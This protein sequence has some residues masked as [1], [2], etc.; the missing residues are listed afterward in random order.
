VTPTTPLGDQYIGH[1][2]AFIML[3]VIVTLLF[4]SSVFA[5]SRNNNKGARHNA[6]HHGLPLNYFEFGFEG[7]T[8]HN[9]TQL[10]RSFELLRSDQF[11][12][13]DRASSFDEGGMKRQ[14]SSVIV[15][16]STAFDLQEALDSYPSSSLMVELTNDIHVNIPLN[17]SR[18]SQLI[19]IN[20][21]GYSLDGGGFAKIFNVLYCSNVIFNNI[22]F[23]NAA[24]SVRC[25]STSSLSLFRHSLSVS[26]LK[27]NKSTLSHTI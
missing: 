15:S 4:C 22:T 20:G 25:P 18:R 27:S 12:S 8:F 13:F 6:N 9:L 3:T 5:G 24:S 16:V 26:T 10:P 19:E 11:S 21:H 7:A 1:F 17:I 14:L 23:A 2:V